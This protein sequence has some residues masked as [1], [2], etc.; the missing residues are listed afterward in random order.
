M[1]AAFFLRRLSGHDMPGYAE[2]YTDMPDLSAWALEVKQIAIPLCLTQGGHLTGISSL[3]QSL[4]ATNA[5]P[6]PPGTLSSA[7]AGR[8]ET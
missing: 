1:A 8:F 2:T 5:F 3:Q 4:V 7:S 6:V